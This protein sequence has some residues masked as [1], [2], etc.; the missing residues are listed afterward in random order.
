[1]YKPEIAGH[2][3][4]APSDRTVHRRA[5]FYGWIQQ[6][7]SLRICI[8]IYDLSDS[9]V[10]TVLSI[11][12]KSLFSGAATSVPPLLALHSCVHGQPRA[13]GVHAGDGAAMRR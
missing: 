9:W 12:Q 1:M 5:I 4:M 11:S 13:P 7:P 8:N 3:A 2:V 10:R 6:L